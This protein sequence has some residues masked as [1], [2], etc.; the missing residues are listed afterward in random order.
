MKKSILSFMHYILAMLFIL[1][2]QVVWAEED[3]EEPK[4]MHW[5]FEGVFGKFDR[6]SIQRG[7]KVYKEVCSVCH[8]LNKVAFRNLADIGFSEEEIKSLAASYSIHDGPN[9]EGEMFERPGRPSDHFPPPYANEQAARASSNNNA[10][11]PDQSL[12]VKARHGGADY[13]YSLLTGYSTPPADF[14]LGENMHYN[15][16]YSGGGKQFSMIP[17]LISDGQV[18][19]D[20][21]TPATI[22]Q[23]A[24]DITNFLQWAAEPEMEERKAL[25]IKTM[26]FTLIFTI[27]FYFAKKHIW[28]RV[29]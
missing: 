12:I 20:D 24:K 3:R 19:F 8:S 2:S 16:Y 1:S 13:I 22:D 21:G 7:L 29:K 27:F 6:N 23:M 10:L 14:T 11:P 28:R 26:I 18:V 25:G 5:S 9:D 17:P 15:P 4:K